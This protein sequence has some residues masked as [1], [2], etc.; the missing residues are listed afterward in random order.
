MFNEH[1]CEHLSEFLSLQKD[2]IEKH[3][4]KHKWFRHI[5]NENDA[6]IDFIQNY[7]WIMRAVFCTHLCPMASGC[8]LLKE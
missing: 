2:I 6:A 5:E 3:L 1:K 8:N 4:E 7:G